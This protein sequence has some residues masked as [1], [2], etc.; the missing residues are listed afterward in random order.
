MQCTMLEHLGKIFNAQSTSTVIS[1]RL[2][3]K[4][5]ST[6]KMKF[7]HAHAYT[8]TK[9][10]HSSISWFTVAEFSTA[11]SC[12]KTA[13]HKLWSLI[14]YILKSLKNLQL[15]TSTWIW[16]TSCRCVHTDLYRSQIKFSMKPLFFIQTYILSNISLNFQSIWLEIKSAQISPK[17][18]LT[19]SGQ[20]WQ[21]ESCPN[22]AQLIEAG[23]VTYPAQYK[24]PVTPNVPSPIT[25]CQ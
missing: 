13:V 21:C 19:L 6:A 11:N 17:M 18:F 7:Y 25:P 5:G 8:Y 14:Q 10:I 4:C 1:G 3:K 12:S 24:T 15:Y 2:G 16:L 20:A 9:E 22:S 23:F